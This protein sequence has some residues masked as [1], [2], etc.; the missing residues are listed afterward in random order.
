MGLG[1]LGSPSY[2]FPTDTTSMTTLSDFESLAEA[3]DVR[4]R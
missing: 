3:P 1:G 2:S 4:C